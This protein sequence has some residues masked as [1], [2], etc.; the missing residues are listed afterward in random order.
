MHTEGGIHIIISSQL[1]KINIYNFP[2]IN[3]NSNVKKFFQ[4]TLTISPLRRVDLVLVI[5]HH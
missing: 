3:K 1:F 5:C 4:I 2:R